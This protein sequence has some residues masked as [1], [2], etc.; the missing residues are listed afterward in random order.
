M[1]RM[2]HIR[3]ALIDGEDVVLE[4]IDGYL[5]CHDH[6]GGRKTLYGY[7]EMPTERLQ[8]LSHDRCYRLVLTDGRKA[9]VYTEVVPS[10]VPGNSI[11]E[12]HVS[13]V[14]KK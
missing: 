9:N 13:G 8:S 4:G 5:A 11:A 14:L 1:E 10:N 3:G 12:F 2:E 7:F 6:K